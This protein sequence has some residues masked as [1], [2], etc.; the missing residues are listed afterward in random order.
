M[1]NI[2]FTGLSLMTIRI[3]AVL[4]FSTWALILIM[5]IIIL[6]KGERGKKWK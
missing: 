1:N 4:W 2:D 5:I 6:Y 3:I